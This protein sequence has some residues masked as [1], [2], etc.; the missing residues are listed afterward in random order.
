MAKQE[1]TLISRKDFIKGAT[2]VGAGVAAAGVFSSCATALPAGQKAKAS[3]K[4][5]GPVIGSVDGKADRGEEADIVVV[6]SGL[7]GFA[8]AMTAIEEG[9]KK[10]VLI[11]KNGY[12]GGSTNFAECNGPGEYTEKEARDAAKAALDSTHYVAD[13]M[14]HYALRAEYKEN[15]DWL[16]VKH[17]VK[18]YKAGPYFYEGGN[19]ASCIKTLVAQARGMQG[20]DMRTETRAIALLLK[21]EHSCV[22]L[23]ATDASGKLV[24]IRAK[25]VILAT[26]GM[27]T[28]KA[29]LAL[30]TNVD[31]EKTI[32]WGV[33]QDGDGQLMVERSAHGRANHLCVASLFN[34]VKG[35]AY[36]SPLGAC[37]SMQPTNLWVN[38][39]GLRFVNEDIQGTSASGKAVEIQGSVFS[40]VDQ[41]HLE[42]YEAGGAQRHYSGFADALVGKNVPGLRDE[43]AKYR[44]LPDVFSADSLEELGR[45]MGVDPA[46]L[47]KTVAAYN[48]YVEAGAD[49]EWG[50]DASKIWP[51][52]RGPFYAFRLSSGMLNTCG[53]IRIDTEAR[54]VD[55]RY[56]PI[57]GLYAAGVCT[58]GWD[59]EVYGGGTCQPA[60]LWAGRKAAKHAV[61]HLL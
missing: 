18:Y 17:G 37:V 50:K 6:G 51:L 29:A 47:A 13:P 1:K 49:A 9:A 38:Q 28:N 34:N 52:T 23:R 59:G 10:V 11:E 31:L 61:A 39:D 2:A 30:Y 20:L 7:G 25:A 16:F 12:W 43:L 3:G 40:I 41:N 54:V 4:E 21:D 46:A 42:K 14:L 53:G 48:G 27:S 24:D 55:P 36:N 15:S 56:R 19:G 58:S 8:A 26:G 32:G 33:G 44:E 22:G 45:K 60:A 35:F 57:A 5:T